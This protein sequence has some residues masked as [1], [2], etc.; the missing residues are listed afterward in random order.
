MAGLDAVE[1]RLAHPVGRSAETDRGQCG[2]QGGQGEHPRLSKSSKKGEEHAGQTR[3]LVTGAN[4]G[5]GLQIAKDL[6][7]HGFTVLVG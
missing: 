1:D 3:A 2:H 5:I 7:A 4:Q 6:T